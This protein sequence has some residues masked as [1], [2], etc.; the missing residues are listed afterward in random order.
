MEGAFET[1][2][3]AGIGSAETPPLQVWQRPIPALIAVL[4][5]AVFSVLTVWFFTQPGP[6]PVVRSTLVDPGLERIGNTLDAG[7]ALSPDGQRIVYFSPVG[8]QG[9][10]ALYVRELD[11]LEPRLLAESARAPFFS[12]D[13]QWV[14]FK[15]DGP[16]WMKMTVAGGPAVSIGGGETGG[17]RGASWG[18]D[19]TIVFATSALSTGLFGIPAAGGE[20]EVLTTPD[21]GNGE[22]DHLFPEFLPDGNSVLFTIT[23]TEGLDNAQIALLDLKTG[24]HRILIPGGS[25]ARY[26]A[27]GH[28]VYGV[29]GTLRAVPFDLDAREVRGTP[30]PVVD[31]VSTR[32]SGAASFSVSPDGTLVYVVGGA[33]SAA[34]QRFVWADRTGRSDP[35]LTIPPGNFGHPR[36]SPDGEH[37]LVGADGDLWIYDMATG[38]R[39]AIT[40][41][42]LTDPRYFAWSP[43][44]S[45]V[46]Y[47]STRSGTS[48]VW[49][50]PADGSGEPQ[51]L[52]QFD[53][54]RADVE[55]WSPNGDV[56]AFHH[57]GSAGADLFMVSP[58]EADPTPEP[59]LATEFAE[60]MTQ[61]SPDGRFV[62]YLSDRT[63]EH[64]LYIRPYPGPGAA[65]T[66]SIDGG[67]EPIW[68]R[69]GELFYRHPVTNAMMGVVVSTEPA[70]TVGVPE[71]LF[72]GQE[73]FGSGP[74]RSPAAD[75]DVAA[76][77]Q[78][79]LMKQDADTE[80][81]GTVPSQIVMV[82]NWFEE[83]KERVPV[84]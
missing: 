47:S 62:A 78:R 32:S 63:G 1:A 3:R 9:R 31:G 72:D 25:D 73:Y 46:A 39:S 83:L 11:Q 23:H 54:G 8:G 27:S 10:G 57:H 48:E 76:D 56:L 49:L 41:D 19:D 68:G 35:I 14:G 33:D 29:A 40:T 65:V 61:F 67:V 44:G 64:Q 26:M 4:L 53:G 80:G 66:V 51:Q 36:L 16:A 79:F 18:P 84:P 58:D 24:E 13:G 37:L 20:A 75:Y 69:N 45:Q 55:S 43:D 74:G 52:T 5:V 22:V 42:Q 81:S 17:A 38:R 12:P 60:E 59:F 34:V 71:Q 15:G 28:I 77:G 82:Q 21:S 30:I 6:Q 50:Q 70:L 2:G 7:V